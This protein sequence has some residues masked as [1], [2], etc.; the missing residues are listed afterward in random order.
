MVPANVSR[1]VSSQA[2]SSPSPGPSRP[3][4]AGRA[5][6]PGRVRHRW[7][8]CTSKTPMLEISSV[9]TSTDVR[10]RF[11][12]D[13]WYMG[14]R[15]AQS[16]V[17]VIHARVPPIGRSLSPRSRPQLD[18]TSDVQMAAVPLGTVQGLVQQLNQGLPNASASD[19]TFSQTTRLPR[20]LSP[21]GSR[22]A[23]RGA[24]HDPRSISQYP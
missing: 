15:F 20:S 23:R 1:L 4:L 10:I 14:R 17:D 21:G 2:V 11:S 19:S 24:R 9:W 22:L 12:M 16:F 3:W 13:L 7:H 5:P 6:G 8:R 18:A